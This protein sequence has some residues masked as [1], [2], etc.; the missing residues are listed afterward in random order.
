M[1]ISLK[2]NELKYS[3]IK[4]NAFVVVKALKNFRF[5]ILHLH[6]VV[7][8]PDIVV[9]SVLTQQDVGCNARGMWIEKTQEYDIK[10][11]PTKLVR[12]NT[13][14]KEIAKNGIFEESEELGEKKLVLVVG[15]QDS[16]FKNI[17][18]LLMYK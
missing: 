17:T 12:G 2:N 11:K 4:K 3:Q 7:Y 14:C 10:I 6:F 1:S 8:V 5:Y 18:Y 9:K 16:W 13:L 15:L